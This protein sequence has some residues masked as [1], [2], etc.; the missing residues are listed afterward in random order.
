MFSPSP[1]T[2]SPRYSLSALICTI[3]SFLLAFLPAF[4]LAFLLELCSMKMAFSPS[5]SPKENSPNLHKSIGTI[6]FKSKA[7]DKTTKTKSKLQ[8]LPDDL[9]IKVE[10]T[11]N[12]LQSIKK[13]KGT[14]RNNKTIFDTFLAAKIPSLLFMIFF[15]C[16][17]CLDNWWV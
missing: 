8:N 2:F 7:M 4:L 14:F 17:S 1:E 15:C 12:I 10:P 5:F 13:D 11:S 3:F 9:R 16:V 6:V